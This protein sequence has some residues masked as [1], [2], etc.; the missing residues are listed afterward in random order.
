MATGHST[1]PSFGMGAKIIRGYLSS[2]HFDNTDC[3]CLMVTLPSEIA[4]EDR[5]VKE[6][7]E[8]VLNHMIEVFSISP[9]G[10]P[11]SR[12]DA[13]RLVVVCWR[14]GTSAGNA[15]S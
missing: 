10:E 13:L 4:K 8:E 2:H 7:F 3:A 14:H 11:G 12:G 15:K 5:Q 6:A 9:N 1:D